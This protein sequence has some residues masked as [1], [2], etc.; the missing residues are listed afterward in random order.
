MLVVK[1]YPF[2]SSKSSKYAIRGTPGLP[3]PFPDSS[4]LYLRRSTSL[5]QTR[6]PLEHLPLH[7]IRHKLHK[8]THKVDAV[9]KEIHDP[10]DEKRG[11]YPAK[12][13]GHKEARERALAAYRAVRN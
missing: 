8:L 4:L 2:L 12:M 7:P 6:D 13:I 3:R 9:P 5:L 11:A 10:P 1:T